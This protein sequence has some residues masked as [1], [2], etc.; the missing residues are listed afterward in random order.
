MQVALEVT[1][2]NGS[3]SQHQ[4]AVAAPQLIKHFAM[5]GAGF[6]PTVELLRRG[7]GAVLWYWPFLRPAIFGG[8]KFGEPVP[9]LQDPTLKAHFSN[10]I[11]R[12]FADH[13]ARKFAHSWATLSYEGVMAVQGIPCRGDR[14]DLLGVSP[15]HVVA[16]EAKGFA[17]RSVSRSDL[18]DYKRQAGTG[19]IAKHSFAASVAYALYS[20]VGVK[21]I[22]PMANTSPPEPREALVLITDYLGL[23]ETSAEAW[24][25]EE[26]LIEGRRFRQIPILRLSE[27]E[28]TNF[29]RGAGWREVTLLL[30]LAARARI[31]R[32]E[33]LEDTAIVAEV[34][35]KDLFVDRDGVGIRLV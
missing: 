7:I 15:S 8:S 26:V 20:K 34:E 4:H 24:R 32:S 25:G 1:D 21:F 12:A 28:S 27:D 33:R 16:L 9:I 5:A 30:D 35:R 14:P 11:G 18:A 17:K 10:L 23:V 22:D 3:T 13:F 6:S 19:P 29:D 31:T 2:A